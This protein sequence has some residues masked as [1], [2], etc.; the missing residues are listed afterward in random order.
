MASGGA[1]FVLNFKA[2]FAQAIAAQKQ[3]V[4]QMARVRRSGGTAL[5]KF[6]A[7]LVL[8]V[9][10]MARA[11]ASVAKL[12]ARL[13]MLRVMTSRVVTAMAGVGIMIVLLRSAAKAIVG[14]EKE[15]G[16]VLSIT[17]AGTKAFG[18][19]RQEVQ[20][21]GATTIYSATQAAEGLKYLVMA[22]LDATVATKNLKHALNLA[23]AGAMDLG[24]AADIVTNIM[25]AFRMA[26]QDMEKA[27]DDIATVASSSN[28]S[29]QQLGDAMKYVSATAKTYGFS[30]QEVAAG[31]GVLSDAGM[32]ASM[33]GTGLRQ[34]FV[35][36]AN[37]TGA[38]A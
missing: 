20:K 29:I 6:N 24:R 25:T 5:T 21:L 3:V 36:I 9:A 19:M 17:N 31:I 15:M 32:Q 13:S 10:R 7:S 22:G 34:V 16:K 12:N 18:M 23:M 27:V 11:R 37:Q 14:F 1:T 33:A 26:G 38:M 4:A 28:T 35:R 8:S 2:K 30:L